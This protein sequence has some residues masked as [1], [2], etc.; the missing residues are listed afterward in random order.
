[1]HEFGGI[2]DVL[3]NR[4]SHVIHWI[5]SFIH[6]P[7]IVFPLASLVCIRDEI[8]CTFFAVS[9]LISF[10][11]FFVPKKELANQNLRNQIIHFSLF[12]LHDY[13]IILI[14]SFFFTSVN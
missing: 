4:V 5:N 2:R 11:F 3:L 7:I 14:R 1:M 9:S 10:P 13:Q 8:Y 6:F 12:L